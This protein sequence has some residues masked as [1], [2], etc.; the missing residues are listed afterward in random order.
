M[1]LPSALDPST[2]PQ[3]ACTSC[4]STAFPSPVPKLLVRLQRLGRSSQRPSLG[5]ICG[6]SY[7]D[8]S[9]ALR[10]VSLPTGARFKGPRGAQLQ[11]GPIRGA[12]PCGAST[13]DGN[14]Q[15]SST[16]QGPTCASDDPLQ[17]LCP[18]S[19]HPTADAL[20]GAVQGHRMVLLKCR[21]DPMGPRSPNGTR[22]RA[23][24]LQSGT[25]IDVL[26]VVVLFLFLVVSA[27]LPSSLQQSISRNVVSRQG[28]PARSRARLPRRRWQTRSRLVGPGHSLGAQY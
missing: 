23:P 5:P 24:S 2:K 20:H 16:R 22:E 14:R 1:H 15:G 13:S 7:L 12:M 8:L 6:R 19:E 18:M 27:S 17:P 21:G 10:L 9:D 3:D 26:D 4:T 28:T 11:S 25:S